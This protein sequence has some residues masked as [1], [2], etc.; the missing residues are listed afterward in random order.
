MLGGAADM[1]QLT[2]T[3][4]NMPE[5]YK[6]VVGER[7]LKLSGGAAFFDPSLLY[8][9]PSMP[10]LRMPACSP[11]SAQSCQPVMAMH[12]CRAAQEMSRCCFLYHWGAAAARRREAAR[13]HSAGLPAPAAAADLRR[14][15]LRAGHRHRARHHGLPGGP[16]SHGP[17]SPGCAWSQASMPLTLCACVVVQELAQG[18]TSVFV[19]HRLSTIR[20]CQKIVVMEAGRVIEQGTH[21]AGPHCLA[22]FSVSTLSV[23]GKSTLLVC[24]AQEL[25]RA[26]RVYFDM[27]AAVFSTLQTNACTPATCWVLKCCAGEQVGGPGS[28]R[29]AAQVLCARAVGGCPSGCLSC[30]VQCCC[31]QKSLTLP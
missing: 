20:N 21:E 18:R 24:H 26:G 23:T 29:Q 15:H 11:R 19:A 16:P 6:T 10:C 5:G 27:C 12:G 9:C 13:G 8:I 28:C 14:G 25:M 1:A 17:G 30:A 3:I 2:K 22:R 31:C 4:A 7:G